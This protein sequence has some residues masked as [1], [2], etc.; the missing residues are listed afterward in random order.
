M[1]DPDNPDAGAWGKAV[2]KHLKSMDDDFVA[3]GHSL[4]GSTI[5]KELAE[6]GVPRRL[7]GVITLAMPF[8]PDWE[9]M[10]YALPQDV[11]RL[12]KVPLMFYFS[13]DDETVAIEHLDRY[14]ELLPHATLR[15]VSSTG[16]LFDKA[17]F[18]KIAGDI[19]T[20]SE[21]RR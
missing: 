21:A 11:S 2:R 15:R 18:G 6:H 17:P 3:V 13:T 12:G 4:G 14:G 5:L 19:A 1:P 16:H 20:L 7:R 8:W 9:V 10:D